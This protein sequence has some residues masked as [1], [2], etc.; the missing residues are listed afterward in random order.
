MRTIS[1]LPAE[2]LRSISARY[3][4]PLGRARWRDGGN[5]L[6]AAAP[7]TSPESTAEQPASPT[8]R[9][10]DLAR[11]EAV[12]LLAR[13]P[14]SSRKLSQFAKLPDGTRARTLVGRLNELYDL[15]GR[16]F[17]VE[18]VAGGYRLLTRRKFAPWLRRLEHVPSE[19]RLSAPALETL[20]VIAY[21]QPVPRADIEAI[22][23]VNCGEVLRQLM[24]RDLVR[25]AGRSEQL[26][27][28]YLYGTTKRFLELFGLRHLDDLPRAEALRGAPLPTNTAPLALPPIDPTIHEPAA[29]E[30]L[31]DPNAD[32]D[33]DDLSSGDLSE[34][35]A[36]IPYTK[37][38]A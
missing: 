13:E 37:E 32:G 22:R 34:E 5:S 25:I 27:R 3:R 14:L 16:A 4:S 2:Q 19:T 35:P 29:A 36:T 30:T 9:D 10:G 28:P 15:A 24:E 12:L 21:R 20:A 33:L 26:G 7:A 11:L 6:L 18:Q 38:F 8:A 31:N 17:R 23:G 1:P